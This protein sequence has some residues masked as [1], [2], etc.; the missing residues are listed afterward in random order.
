MM[1]RLSASLDDIDKLIKG[2]NAYKARINQRIKILIEKLAVYGAYIA[3]IEFSNA[4]YAGDND[5]EIEVINETNRSIILAKGEAV[6]FIEFGTGIANPDHPLKS[7]LGIPS[8]GTYGQGKGKQKAWAY[9]GKQGT[10]GRYLKTTPK[11]DLY[12][13]QGNP[14]AQAMYTASREIR[15]RLPGLIKEVFS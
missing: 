4:F 5:V 8:H 7:E 11:G 13:T 10:A 2:V 14:P 12:L 15:D 9:Y 6:G 1:I 3:R